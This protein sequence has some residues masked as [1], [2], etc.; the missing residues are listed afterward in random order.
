[1]ALTESSMMALGSPAPSF[2]LPSTDGEQVTLANF[3]GKEG[4]VVMF[5]CNHC[6]YVIHIAPAL[7]KLA[8]EYQQKNIGFVAIS[9][10][11]ASTYPADSFE[12][13]KEE[14]AK[15]GYTFA[16]LYDES[17]AVAKAYNAAC[18]PDIYLFDKE[19]KLV[20]RGQFDDTRPHRISSGNYDS[21]AAPATGADLKAA[22]DLL[23]AGQAIPTKQYP[24]IGCNIK[25]KDS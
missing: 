13:M 2:S 14:K 21:S 12:L 18:T 15:Q 20:Y 4:L 17:Q 3:E 8:A 10:N 16:Y 11:D 9:S 6:P 23:L 1:M 22:L 7:A 24:S 25:W 19:Q 5:I